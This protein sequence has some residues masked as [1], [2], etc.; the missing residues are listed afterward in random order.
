MYRFGYKG[1]EI[2]IR[3]TS[4][5]SNSNKEYVYKK[6][7]SILDEIIG[8]DNGTSFIVEDD[9]RRLVVGEIQ[10]GELIVISIQHIVETTQIFIEKKSS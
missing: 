5:A 4:H 2:I 7:A 1:Q 9:K 6:I 3:F 10:K 8:A